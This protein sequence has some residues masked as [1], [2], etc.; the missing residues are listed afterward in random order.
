MSAKHLLYL[1]M[2]L[3]LKHHV[4]FEIFVLLSGAKINKPGCL[5]IRRNTTKNDHNKNM[6]FQDSDHKNSSIVLEAK[7]RQNR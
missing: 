6:R 3:H 2:F 7:A 5:A 4:I 1:C